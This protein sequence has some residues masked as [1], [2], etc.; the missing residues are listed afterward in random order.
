VA[1]LVFSRKLN[2]GKLVTHQ[3]PMQDTAAAV[4][5][6]AHPTDSSLK[7]VVNDELP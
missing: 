6:A 3:F 2:A 5:L 7:V 4:E 1:R